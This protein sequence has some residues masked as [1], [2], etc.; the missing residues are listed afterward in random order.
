MF[1]Q[2]AS[3]GKTVVM[4]THDSSLARRVNR[5]VIIADGEV[6]NEYVA[7]ALNSL[8]P[9][10]MLE[11]SRKAQP[12]TYAPGTTIIQQDTPG[13][14]FYIITKGTAEVALKREG[15]TDVI[16]A[17]MTAGQYFGEISLFRGSRTVASVR[18]IQE[19]PVEVLALDR[20]T[21]MGLA[22]ESQPFRDSLTGVVQA[23]LENNQVVLN[24][25]EPVALHSNGGQGE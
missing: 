4:V 11:A 19:A 2:L 18:A 20:E 12:V 10:Q 8:T 6:V 5:T 15:G 24:Q 9:Q 3:E 25:A 16:A 22:A 13:D 1:E 7:R 23:R 14:R 21:F 17:R